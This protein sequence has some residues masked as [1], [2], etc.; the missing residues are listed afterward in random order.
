MS[1][2]EERKKLAPTQECR[3]T[4]GRDLPYTYFQ[5]NP[6]L[7]KTSSVFMHQI[8]LITFKDWE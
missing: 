8:R 1:A 6:R 2:D 7:E 3:Q 5:I 4:K